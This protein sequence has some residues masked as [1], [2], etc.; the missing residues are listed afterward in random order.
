LLDNEK[1]NECPFCRTPVATS[2]KE[3]VK[4]IMKRVEANDPLAIYDLG[5][6]YR[7]GA[8]GFPQNWN[9][10]LE[11]FNQA[12]ELGYAEAYTNVGYVYH[13]G[14][15]VE[16]DKKKAEH[17]FE[18]AAML[19]SVAARYNLGLN[20]GKTGNTDRALKHFMIGTKSGQNESLKKIKE[21]YK[22]GYATKEDYTKAL[23][24]YQE[25]LGD[26]KSSQ[27]DEAAAA[28]NDWYRYY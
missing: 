9:K 18:L 23:Q 1:Q 3:I 11:L 13:Q 22:L 6:H 16:R 4:R 17:Y 8:R 10:A 25:Y 15:G 28:H 2:D 14:H 7:E 19:G 27:R 20:E 5:N 26:I 24:S 12:G 21:L